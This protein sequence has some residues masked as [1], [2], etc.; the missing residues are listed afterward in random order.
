MSY[1]KKRL[2]ELKANLLICFQQVVKNSVN[3]SDPESTATF[4]VVR[5]GV[6][7]DVTVYWSLGPDAALDFYLPL[8]GSLF[9]RSVII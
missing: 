2:Q 9:F 6:T 1:V 8:H 5:A 3:Q 7:G 4:T